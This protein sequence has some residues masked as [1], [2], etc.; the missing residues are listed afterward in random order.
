MLAIIFYFIT[1]FCVIKT[2][3]RRIKFSDFP[4]FKINQSGVFFYSK[5]THR[6]KIE[7]DEVFQIQKNLYIRTKNEIIIIKNVENVKIFENFLYFK[8]LGKVKIIFNIKQIYNYLVLLVESKQID[9]NYL[10]QIAI[11]DLINNDFDIN[12][13]KLLKKYIKIL[14]N[15]L[16]IGIFKE[17]IVV[18]Q[19]KYKIPFIL[20]YKIN[21]KIK[22]VCVNETLENL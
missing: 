19:N 2:R 12:N 7:N 9:M 15:V 11:I 5:Q 10:R 8:A 17:K 18:K 6:I 4:Q 22:K 1:F 13:S 20:T 21:N 3:K 14:K 16:N